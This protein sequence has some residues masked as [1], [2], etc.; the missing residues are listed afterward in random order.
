MPYDDEGD[1]FSEDS[2][3]GG[4]PAWLPGPRIGGIE[5]KPHTIDWGN[6]TPKPQGTDDQPDDVD[7]GGD[8]PGGES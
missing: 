4:I 3:A 1:D 8:R 7:A 2:G 6:S 5:P